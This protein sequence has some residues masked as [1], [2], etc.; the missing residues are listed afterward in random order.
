MNLNLW[1]KGLSGPF[2]FKW[3]PFLKKQD[4]I[5]MLFVFFLECALAKKETLSAD[6]QTAPY[7]LDKGHGEK[8]SHNMSRVTQGKQPVQRSE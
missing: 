1:T 4:N 6:L 7:G 2:F 3:S 8:N 5:K